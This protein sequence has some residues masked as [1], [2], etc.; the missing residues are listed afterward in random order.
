MTAEAVR[1]LLIQRLDA[2]NLEAVKAD[3]RPFLRNPEEVSAW[4][5][6]LF[7]DAIHRLKAL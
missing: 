2:L 5:K 7:L 4:S 1:Q 6:E 3:V